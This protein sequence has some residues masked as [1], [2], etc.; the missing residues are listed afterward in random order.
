MSVEV[1]SP[2]GYTHADHLAEWKSWKDDCVGENGCGFGIIDVDQCWR[3]H[4][5][6]GVTA[7]GG[8][9]HGAVSGEGAL[10]RDELAARWRQ[11]RAEWLREAIE[12]MATLYGE[13]RWI[14]GCTSDHRKERARRAANRRQAALER[15]TQWLTD[16]VINPGNYPPK[17]AGP[18]Q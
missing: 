4:P 6:D 8:C 9:G 18:H 12:D 16:M 10:T 1:E 3:G 13:A 2:C 5:D 15:L 7:C 17:P 11:R 14:V